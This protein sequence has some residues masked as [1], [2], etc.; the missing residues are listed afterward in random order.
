MFL[1]VSITYRI[2]AVRLKLVRVNANA[3]RTADRVCSMC[4]SWLRCVKTIAGLNFFASQLVV[5]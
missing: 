2:C 1:Y 4:D 3:L 5:K